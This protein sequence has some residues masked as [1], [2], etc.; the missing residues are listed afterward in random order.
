M[1][2]ML[3][4]EFLELYG[5]NFDYQRMGISLNSTPARSFFWLHGLARTLV[6]VDPFDSSN[7]IGRGVFA[8][9]RIKV[10]RTV[11]FGPLL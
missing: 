1:Q 8:M 3:L 9:W 6:I 2:G 5:R 11:I 4:L 10:Q 7:S